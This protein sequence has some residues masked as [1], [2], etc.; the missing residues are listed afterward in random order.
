MQLRVVAPPR[1]RITRKA[2]SPVPAATSSMS[3][4]GSAAM[5]RAI[6]L[7]QMRWMPRLNK[8]HNTS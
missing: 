2:M 7:F 3:S 6:L 8:S 5:R 1:L 4:H